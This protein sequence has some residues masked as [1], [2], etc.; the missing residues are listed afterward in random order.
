MATPATNDFVQTFTLKSNQIGGQF[1]N[2]Q[3]A[4]AM[5]FSAEN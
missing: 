2:K 1:T 5:G 3:Y 4:N